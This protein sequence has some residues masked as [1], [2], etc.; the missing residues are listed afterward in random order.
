M[1]IADA[2]C[3]ATWLLLQQNINSL[4]TDLQSMVVRRRFDSDGYNTGILF[5]NGN[6]ALGI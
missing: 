2:Q 3:V 4:A 1:T 5:K 6:A